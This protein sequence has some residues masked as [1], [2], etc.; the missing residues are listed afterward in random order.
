MK[1]AICVLL[2][3]AVLLT[4]SGVC[5]FAQ[6]VFPDVSENAWYYDELV[7]AKELGIVGGFSDG[8]FKPDQKV[9]RG[10]FLRMLMR[11]NMPYA[12][13]QHWASGIYDECIRKKYLSPFIFTK[14]QLDEPIQR[15]D[16]ALIISNKL[17]EDE[18]A[19]KDVPFC[20]FSDIEAGSRYEYA[21]SLCHTAGILLGYSDGSFRPG[22]Y[23]SRAQAAAV[24]VRLDNYLNEASAN[25]PRSA[26][27]YMD[28]DCRKI[29]GSVLETLEFSGKNG[30]YYLSYSQP[31]I[32]SEYHFGL[33]LTIYEKQGE[34]TPTLYY[35]VSDEAYMTHPENYD[36]SA[37]SVR[38]RINGVK[39]LKDKLVL[40]Q[41]SVRSSSG[42][43]ASY[44][45]VQNFDGSRSIDAVW[46]PPAG[47]NGTVWSQNSRDLEKIFTWK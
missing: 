44:Q 31:D 1:K 15:G 29:L 28:A 33:E 16:M 19:P 21:V 43:L 6:P 23:L 8:S 13:W 36:P 18:T 11:G 41:M 45:I 32:P 2:I 30:R 35:Y 9:S 14:G 37:H 25:E 38:E 34:G 10:Q 42:E 26:E 4:A 22:V 40:C 46:N 27:E 12:K 47:S 3:L 7:K 24:F 5:V 39:S 20:S 17:I